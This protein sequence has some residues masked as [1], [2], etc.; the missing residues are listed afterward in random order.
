M[1]NKRKLNNKLYKQ[2]SSLG[3][4]AEIGQKNMHV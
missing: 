2:M 4:K 1:L 3:I